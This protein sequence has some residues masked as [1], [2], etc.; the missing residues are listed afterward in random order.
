MRARCRIDV[1]AGTHGRTRFRTAAGVGALT[2]RRT[3]P[4]RVHLVAAAGGP[5]GGDDYELDIS[6]GSGARLVVCTAAA[7]VVLAA[8][9][10][11]ASKLTVRADVAEGGELVLTPNP[12]LLTSRGRHECD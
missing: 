10:G 6:V 5:L 3:G 4:D 1:E 9:P 11:Q 8:G 7:S 2:P 12:I